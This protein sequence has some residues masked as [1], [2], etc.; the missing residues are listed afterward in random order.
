MSE[1]NARFYDRIEFRIVESVKRAEPKKLPDGSIL[2]TRKANISD[3][4]AMGLLPSVTTIIDEVLASGKGLS[5]WIIDQHIEACIEYP[6]D[7]PKT[8]EDVEAYKAMIYAKANEYRDVTADRGKFLHGEV[9]EW[10]QHAREPSDPAATTMVYALNEF[11]E[12]N[13][14]I[15]MTSERCLGSAALGYAGTPD[16]WATTSS[17]GNILIDLKTTK[18]KGYKKPYDKWI[19]QL[20]GYQGLT[21]AEAEP[22]RLFQW[23]ADRDSGTSIFQEHDNS[24]ETP[25][26]GFRKI[27]DLWCI[28]KDYYPMHYATSKT[29]E[30]K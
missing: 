7:R 1:T 4:R 19:F 9:S 12:R 3:A 28:I 26:I 8:E 10:I 13:H 27:L 2:T 20:G 16:I 18:L 14:V 15:A 29:N 23:V 5:D 24:N 22:C 21:C 30:A 6:F 25:M 11:A 17:S